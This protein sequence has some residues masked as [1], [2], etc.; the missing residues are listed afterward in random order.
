MTATDVVD[1]TVLIRWPP[2]GLRK[3]IVY[4]W[5]GPNFLATKSAYALLSE[6]TEASLPSFQRETATTPV[7]QAREKT[8]RRAIMTEADPSAN[9]K[10][11]HE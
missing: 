11:S 5:I 10:C 8:P 1:R 2:A 6:S 9:K 3:A 4:G 7:G